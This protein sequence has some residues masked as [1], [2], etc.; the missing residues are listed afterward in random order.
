GDLATDLGT[1]N[2]VVRVDH[3]SGGKVFNSMWYAKDYGLVQVG[4]EPKGTSDWLLMKI[5]KYTAQPAPITL[6]A[7]DLFPLASVTL[8]M[9]VFNGNTSAGTAT[10]TL[11][12]QSTTRADM[13]IQAENLTEVYEHN[14]DNNLQ[15]TSERDNGVP[16]VLLKFPLKVGKEWTVGQNGE[17]TM[18]VAGYGPIQVPYGNVENAVRVVRLH[19]GK[20]TDAYWF[21]SGLGFVQ[22]ESWMNGA[23]VPKVYKLSSRT[24]TP[25]PSPTAL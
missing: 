22:V 18:V 6:M 19:Q 8:T 21:A 17:D 3:S 11:V 16:Q 13:T 1:L 15:V 9:D 24:P 25:S 10:A 5:A 23:S 20:V 2:N 14:T 7:D 12:N 4:F